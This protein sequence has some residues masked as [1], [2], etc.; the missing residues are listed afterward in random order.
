MSNCYKMENSGRRYNESK[1]K[2]SLID[3]ESLEPLVRVMEYGMHKYTIYVDDA[4]DTYK[5]S[6]IT[7][8]DVKKLDLKVLSSGKENWK[9]GLDKTAILE[10]SQ[11]HLIDLFAGRKFDKES[12]LPSIGHLLANAMFYSYYSKND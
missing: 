9:N 4:G 3:F 7:L 10:S 1:P 6:E 2:W 12:G 8:E 5:G 11:R